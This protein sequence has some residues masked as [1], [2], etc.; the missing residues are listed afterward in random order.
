MR[1][2]IFYPFSSPHPDRPGFLSPFQY[3]IQTDYLMGR[4]MAQAII[5]IRNG[6]NNTFGDKI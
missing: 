1:R 4:W 5:G 2:A 6:T 3:L